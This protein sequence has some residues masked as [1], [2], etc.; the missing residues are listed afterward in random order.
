ME[1]KLELVLQDCFAF[2]SILSLIMVLT[3]LLHRS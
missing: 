2:L 1:G 3:N